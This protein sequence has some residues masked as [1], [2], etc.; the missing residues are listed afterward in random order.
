M[1]SF[2]RKY[3]S[4]SVWLLKGE[5]TGN[6]KERKAK[7]GRKWWRVEDVKKGNELPTTT[8]TKM[9]PPNVKLY[10]F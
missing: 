3:S 8:Y 6:D 2:K 10:L 7:S 4:E 9:D 5:D 1:H